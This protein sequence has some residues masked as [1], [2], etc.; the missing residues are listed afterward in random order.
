VHN[1]KREP[2]D[3]GQGAAVFCVNP[4]LGSLP[5]LKK[6]PISENSAEAEAD[7][8]VNL[9]FFFLPEGKNL[10]FHDATSRK[11]RERAFSLDTVCSI[12]HLYRQDLF[13][14]YFCLATEKHRC[15]QNT[16]SAELQGVKK[17]GTSAKNFS[18]GKSVWRILCFAT[19][20][21]VSA[22]MIFV[23]WSWQN[24]LGED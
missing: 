23:R 8:S 3:R 13:T 19:L 5:F 14:L 1:E 21:K 22:G 7:S 10:D 17:K 4:S 18:Y 12:Y 11:G 2:M 24:R 16:V 9:V 6:H 20:A 15:C